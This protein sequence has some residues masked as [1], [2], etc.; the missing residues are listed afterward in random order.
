M[1][2]PKP[3]PRLTERE[4]RIAALAAAPQM[5]L[6]TMHACRDVLVRG[7]SGY[8]AAR[9]RGMSRAALWR[10]LERIEAYVSSRSTSASVSM[11]QT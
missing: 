2:A 3:R 7:K 11:M 9:E 5:S 6:V 1:S 4:F 8:V 10:Q